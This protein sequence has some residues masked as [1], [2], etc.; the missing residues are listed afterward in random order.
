MYEYGTV[1]PVETVLRRGERG[2]EGEGWRGEF[3]SD[4]L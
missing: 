4:I 2:D 3:N 1:R